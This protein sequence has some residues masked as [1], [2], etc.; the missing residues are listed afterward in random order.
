V[1]EREVS[2]GIS[3]L[4]VDGGRAIDVGE[5]LAAAAGG[6]EGGTE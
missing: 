4:R 3:K 6:T 5:A 2:W 1:V